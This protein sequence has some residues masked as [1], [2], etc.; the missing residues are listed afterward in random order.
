MLEINDNWAIGADKDNIILYR[1]TN[2]KKEGQEPTLRIVGYFGNLRNVLT[3]LVDREV[4]DTQLESFR[5]ITG[6]LDE[7]YNLIKNLPSITVGDLK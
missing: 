3:A 7:I 1:K 6:K 5:I 4:K 2:H